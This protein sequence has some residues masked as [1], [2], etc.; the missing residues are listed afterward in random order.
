MNYFAIDIEISMNELFSYLDKNIELLNIFEFQISR[1]LLV[2]YPQN[3]IFT[4]YFC[5]KMSVC[6]PV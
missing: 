6:L 4:K 3:H 2:K 5:L 1:D